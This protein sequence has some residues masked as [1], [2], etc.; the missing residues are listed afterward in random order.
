MAYAKKRP[1]EV[2][3]ADPKQWGRFTGQDETL[4]PT[5]KTGPVESPLEDTALIVMER[6]GGGVFA[7]VEQAERRRLQLPHVQRSGA[8]RFQVGCV[9]NGAAD[10]A[11]SI[12]A[13][14]C[15]HAAAVTWYPDFMREIVAPRTELKWSI[16]AGTARTWLAV[17]ERKPT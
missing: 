1:R 7:V 14:C 5:C 17:K 16:D 10:L 4:H 9:G 3:G 15:G 6:T 12:L 8:M 11:L 13:A 2:Q